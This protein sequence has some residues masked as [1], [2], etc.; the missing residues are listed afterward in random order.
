[1]SGEMKQQ[2]V[3]GFIG[4]LDAG[5]FEQKL[6]RAIKDVSSGVI[7]GEKAKKGKITIT[8]DITR[9]GASAQVSVDHKLSYSAPTDK[10]KFSEED[11]TQT[12]MYVHRG[13]VLDMFPED[14]AQMFGK[15]GEVSPG[16]DQLNK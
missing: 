9:I 6:A 5:V 12:I 4:D 7:K 14:Q 8:F 10:G 13:G 1:M 16:A 15:K 11:T 3:Q 2:D